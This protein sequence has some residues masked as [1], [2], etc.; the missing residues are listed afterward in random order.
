MT[1]LEASLWIYIYISVSHA[2]CCL[3]PRHC[4]SLC[5]DD[6][7]ISQLSSSFNGILA[8]VVEFPLSL[9][10]DKLRLY[11]QCK[12]RSEYICLRPCV[13]QAWCLPNLLLCSSLCTIFCTNHG[14]MIPFTQKCISALSLAPF[15]LH[16]KCFKIYFK[17]IVSCS[18]SLQYSLCGGFFRL[19]VHPNR[20][21]LSIYFFFSD[22]EIHQHRA[23]IAH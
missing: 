20:E 4:L 11:R 23:L 6:L 8:E 13:S 18:S 12:V 3:Y 1:H 9:S 2:T 15:K 14:R 22:V 19:Q 17:S 5:C 21:E 10:K 7:F 16:N